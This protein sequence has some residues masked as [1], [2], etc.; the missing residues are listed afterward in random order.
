MDSC[1]PALSDYLARLSSSPDAFPLFYRRLVSLQF[2]IAVAEILELRYLSH[3]IIDG[4]SSDIAADDT[5]VF[6]AERQADM[7]QAGIHQPAHRARLQRLL[8]LT[9]Q[10]YSAHSHDSAVHE[11]RL[12]QALADNTFGRQHSQ[13]YGRTTGIATVIALGSSLLLSP[14]AILMQ[15]LAVLFGYLSLDYFYS[16]STLRREEQRLRRELEAV[17][18]CR[19]RAINWK[20]V[21]RQSGAILGYTQP[22]GGEAFR[23]VSEDVE[24]LSLAADHA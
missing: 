4:A 16:V 17:L 21:V 7:T 2:P 14:P 24:L 23:L 11:T 1:K 8:L 3:Q 10:F 5:D 6:L 20:A 18:R 13:R 19:V 9:R 12:R 15:G 22:H